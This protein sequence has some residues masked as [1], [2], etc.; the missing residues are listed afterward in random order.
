MREVIET[1]PGCHLIKVQRNSQWARA[2]FSA[3]DNKTQRE[4][5]ELAYKLRKKLGGSNDNDN[6]DGL[7]GEIREV[8]FRIKR[9]LPSAGT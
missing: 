4:V 7:S 1:I 9:I 3:P 8:V 2:Y 6:P 5:L